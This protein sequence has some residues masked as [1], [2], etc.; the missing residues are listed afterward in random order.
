M[1]ECPLFLGCIQG[2]PN[3]FR[4]ALHYWL[5]L[6]KLRQIVFG[7]VKRFRRGKSPGELMVREEQALK[8]AQ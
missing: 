1:R 6:L 7:A 2:L 5:S 3:D 8:S 4:D